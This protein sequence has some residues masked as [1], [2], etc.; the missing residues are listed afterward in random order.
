MI[1]KATKKVN[2]NLMQLSSDI[3]LQTAEFIANCRDSFFFF[4]QHFFKIKTSREFI[5]SKPIGREP[6]LITVAKELKRCFDLDVNR[7]IINIPPGHHKSTILS[8][9]VA[10]C[11]GKYP[12]ANFLYIS[13]AKPL[14]TKHTANIKEIM[15]LPEYGIIF[16]GTVLDKSSKAKDNFKTTKGGTVVAF[17]SSGSITGQDA[18]LPG[19][20]RFSGAVLMD[21]MHKPD[22]VHSDVMRES[23]WDN[24]NQTIKYR[25]RDFTHVPLICMGQR[26]HEEDICAKLL[27]GKDGYEWERIVLK[28]LDDNNQALYPEVFSR[29][30]LLIEKEINPYSFWSQHQ[31]EPVPAGNALFYE[32]DM[33]VFLEEPEMLATFICADTAETS[34][35]INDATAF[36]FFGLYRT[37]QG[38]LAIHCIHGV[39]IRVEP[40]DLEEEFMHFYSVCS[41]Y[42]MPPRVAFIEKKSTG[43]TLVS[44]LR[45]LQGIKIWDIERTRISGS[46]TQRFLNVQT[47]FAQRRF[48]F[49]YGRPHNKVFI[50][51]LTRITANDTHAHDDIA[52]ICTD[53]ITKGLIEQVIAIPD[54]TENNAVKQVMAAQNQRIEVLRQ[55]W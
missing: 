19:L 53:A 37:A 46:K 44:V 32:E 22:E 43:V 16:P 11:L 34:K 51:H 6:H 36:G 50:N 7:L 52:D 30:A 48:T 29:E 17:G 14:A 41:R 15:E 10:W 5:L 4:F 47:Y 1:T 2:L 28:S 31:Q 20:T 12:D 42:K 45:S 40:R 8:Y 27:A 35:S 55:S 9:W 25:P 33:L 39:E 13:Y 26:L 49:T 38:Q 21:D 24:Y 3:N 18:G 54:E 23:V